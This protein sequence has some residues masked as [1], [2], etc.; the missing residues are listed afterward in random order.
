M[1]RSKRVEAERV[2]VAQIVGRGGRWRARQ[3]RRVLLQEFGVKVE[4]PALT[5]HLQALREEGVVRRTSGVG[6]QFWTADHVA[7]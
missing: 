6:E 5:R 1:G 4:G 3:V 2:L 7:P